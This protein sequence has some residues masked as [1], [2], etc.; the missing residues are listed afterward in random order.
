MHNKM[1]SMIFL[2]FRIRNA[3]TGTG[4]NMPIPMPVWI[5]SAETRYLLSE[6]K[7]FQN[8]LKNID[9]VY[10]SVFF[11]CIMI[12]SYRVTFLCN[13]LVKLIIHQKALYDIFLWK[14][15]KV[16][17]NK[18]TAKKYISWIVSQLWSATNETRRYKSG[19]A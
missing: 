17:W 3:H 4:W 8:K 14:S 11:C 6:Q 15:C 5:V 9:E 18:K 2:L 12:L 7:K 1:R 19:A 13:V 16:V 10:Q